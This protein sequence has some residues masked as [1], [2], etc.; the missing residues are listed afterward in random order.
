MA[1]ISLKTVDANEAVAQV[2]YLLSEV[3]ALYPITPAS[4]MGEWVDKWRTEKKTNL[5]G[6]LPQVVEM[7]SEGGV[8]GAIHG[9]LLSGSLATTFTASQGLLLM[10]PNMFKIAGELLPAVFHVAS[11][12]VA[13]HALSIFGDHSDVMAARSTGF[14]LLNSQSVQEAADIAVVAHLSAL[15][16]SLPFLH[17]FDGFRTSHE[18]N[19]VE[20]VD[21]TLLKELVS[22]EPIMRFRQR[23][24]NPEKPLLYGSSQ[25]PDTFFQ[26]RERINPYY[27]ACP[28]IVQTVM[29]RFGKLTGRYYKLYEYHGDPQAT[30]VVVVMGSAAQTV[31]SVVDDLNKKGWKTGVVKVRLFGPFDQHRFLSSFPPTTRSIAVLDRCKEPTAAGEPL[32]L[33]VSSAIL[34]NALKKDFPFRNIPRVIGGRYGLSSKEFSPAMAKAVFDHLSKEEGWSDFTVGIVD[35]VSDR[36]IPLDESYSLEKQYRY[37]AVFYGLGSDGTVSANKNTVKIVGEE[38]KLFAQGYFVY[39]SKKSGSLTI[40]HLRFDTQPIAAPY[41][42]EKPHFVGCHQFEFIFKYDVLKGIQKEGILL[43]NSPFGAE[44]TWSKLP[45]AVQKKI[46][47]K[48]I[49]FFIIDAYK[50][51]KESGLGSRINTIMQVSFFELSKLIAIEDALTFIKKHIR[52][53]Y[54]YR[55]EE[56]INRNY[57]A[58]EKARTALFEIDY[59]QK[60]FSSI[61]QFSLIPK[62]APRYVKEVIGKMIA[63]EGDKLPVSSFSPY[64][65]FPTAT[66]QWEKRNI[67]IEVPLWEPSVC[68]QCGKCVIACPHS[69]IRA[70]VYEPSYL[71]K[72]PRGFLKAQPRY[73]EWEGLLYSI[74]VSEADCTGC[75][76]CVDVCP[77]FDKYQPAKKALNMTVRKDLFDESR[78]EHFAFFE[79]LPDVEKDKIDCQSLRDVALLRPLFEYPGAC[80]GCG[81]SPYLKLLSQLFGDR[82]LIANAT[83]CSSIYGGNLPTTPWAKDKEGRGPAWANSLFE[84]NAEFG[85]GLYLGVDQLRNLTQKRLLDLTKKGV[86][87]NGLVQDL[88]EAEEKSPKEYSDQRKRIKLLQ[89]KLKT[90]EQPEAYELLKLSGYLSRKS[91]WIIGGDGWAYDIGLGGLIHVLALNYKVNVL[92]LDT[93]VYSNTGGQASKATPRGA[94]AKFAASGKTTP[95]MDLA[96]MAIS[97]GNV[98]VASVAVGADEEHTI[99]AFLEADAFEGPSLILAYAHCIAHGIDMAKAMHHQK[100][101]VAS[102]RWPIFRYNPKGYA[103]GKH[104]KLDWTRLI[105]GF[106]KTELSENRFRMLFLS[107]PERAE[108]LLA[109][110]LADCRNRVEYYKKMN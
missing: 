109:L 19:T 89:E 3:I 51:A 22:L 75:Q 20:L 82:M 4:P 9:A 63:L 65:D 69:V 60:P 33:Q 44:Q 25:N 67:S 79:S 64:G 8:A 103:D 102:G 70:K 26:A 104:L 39:D 86:I 100:S 74:A 29:D 106:E 15:E 12:T 107:D 58:L 62:E 42:V 21:E 35:D 93:E 17:F 45:E 94:V 6:L 36:S 110:A 30:L 77:A 10:L 59:E 54:G 48:K 78:M 28:G 40:S 97:L 92:V 66:S 83:G 27:S 41:L 105:E 13:T 2:A 18:I 76:I 47:D 50:I 46:K 87:E 108:D 23:A 90:L 56:V 80:A 85:L 52:S 14:A 96:L 73:P 38:G 88:I 57:E 11:R 7:Q 91:V 34:N 55:G 84:D 68:I 32:L 16:S 5:W 24:L 31:C 53:S 1:N 43:L 95:K 98:Y 81:E 61:P 71:E 49:R 101:V 72:A 99:N 37:E